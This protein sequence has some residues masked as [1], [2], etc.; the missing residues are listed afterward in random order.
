[1]GYCTGFTVPGFAH[2]PLG[3]R[4]GGVGRL[5]GSRGR[6]FRNLCHAYGLPAWVSPYAYPHQ[7]NGLLPL[8]AAE[9][10]NMLKNQ[11]RLVQENLDTIN[12]RIKELEK[13]VP[14][15]TAS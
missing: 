1:M 13:T 15:N 2:S 11:A 5:G 4:G 6:G 14:E 12:K 8:T 3:R 10:A 7:A 9:E